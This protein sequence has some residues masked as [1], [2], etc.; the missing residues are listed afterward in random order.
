MRTGYE[1]WPVRVRVAQAN[2][3]SHISGSLTGKGAK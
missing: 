2:M 3:V 1:G